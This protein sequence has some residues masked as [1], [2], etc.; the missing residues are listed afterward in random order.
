M[1]YSTAHTIGTQLI[2]RVEDQKQVYHLEW[3]KPPSTVCLTITLLK[4]LEDTILG[5]MN[6]L[7]TFAYP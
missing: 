4:S 2:V 1:W 7:T 5:I 3:P 6:S